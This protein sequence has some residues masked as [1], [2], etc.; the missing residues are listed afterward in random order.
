MSQYHPC[1]ALIGGAIVNLDGL[2]SYL[3]S[4]MLDRGNVHSFN[5]YPY[6]IPAIRNLTELKLHP[7]VT[8]FV[9]DNGTGKSTLLE[10]IAVA[11]GFN[12]EGGSR[13]LG[14][15]SYDTHS[16]LHE[17]MRLCKGIAKP[18]DGYFLRAESFYNVASAI[19]D[20]DSDPD[21]VE[22][23]SGPPI[24]SSYGG[25]S[26]HEQSHGESFFTLLT[27]RFNGQG[28]YL[29]DEPEAALSPTRQMSVLTIMH[30]LLGRQSQFII[31]THSP[32]IMAYPDST[33]YLFSEDAITPIDYTE[34]EHYTVT[35][36]FLSRREAM[37][38]VLLRDT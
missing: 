34:T 17:N 14:F 5:Q 19:E 37:L 22:N 26:L 23:N 21:N 1:Q 24:I 35:L 3:L 33:I 4:V 27:R 32:I 13:N 38:R 31:V 6:C 36:D 11:A 29:L 12:P 28:L 18:R 30:E 2:E 9:G 10:A 25:R 15:S 8:Y 16:G 20:I 7:K